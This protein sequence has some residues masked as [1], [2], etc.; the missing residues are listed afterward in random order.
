MAFACSEQ[1]HALTRK[2]IEAYLAQH[3]DEYGRLRA[4]R[5]QLKSDPDMFARSNMVGHITSSVLVFDAI[6]SNVLLINHK[7][8]R[9]WMQPGGHVEPDSVSLLA[10]GLR[11]V[12]EET[13]LPAVAVQPLLQGRVLDIDTHAIAARPAK[14]EGSH[15]HHDFLFVAMTTH[16]FKPQPQL[17]EVNGVE[18]VRVEDFL[19]VPG[20]RMRFLVPKLR[21]LLADRNSWQAGK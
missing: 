16:Q 1:M 17:D 14:G 15:Q 4:L 21:G 12:Q 5:D 18:W 8:Y 19:A 9:S 13:G 3:P 7:V 6:G 2:A 11:E 20:Q 10:S